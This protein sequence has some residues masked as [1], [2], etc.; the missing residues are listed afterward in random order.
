MVNFTIATFHPSLPR[1]QILLP[2]PSPPPIS[3]QPPRS[4][5]QYSLLT[6]LRWAWCLLVHRR[7]LL[8]QR[9]RVCHHLVH[10]W[11]YHPVGTDRVRLHVCVC[12][13]V[14]GGGSQ[15]REGKREGSVIREVSGTVGY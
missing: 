14:I 3:P 11:Y 13:C 10:T 7:H 6:W 15:Y 5:L 4:H 2:P 8:V 1:I 12:A 9:L